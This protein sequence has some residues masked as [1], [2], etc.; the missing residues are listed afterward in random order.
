L[1]TKTSTIMTNDGVS[2][3]IEQVAYALKVSPASQQRRF[4]R[5]V[6]ESVYSDSAEIRI[7]PLPIARKAILLH[8]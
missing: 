6:E 7:K 1:K 3:A 4:E 8:R 5:W 2:S